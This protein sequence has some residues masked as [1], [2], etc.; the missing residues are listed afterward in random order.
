[1]SV[2]L[3]LLE[4]TFPEKS[5]LRKKKSQQNQP[6]K[7]VRKTWP[8]EGRETGEVKEDWLAPNATE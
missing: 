6:G 3:N 1:M 7:E 4:N 2:I 8:Q 5:I